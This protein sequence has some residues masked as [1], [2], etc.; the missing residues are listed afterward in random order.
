MKRLPIMNDGEWCMQGKNLKK[1]KDSGRITI[2]CA[3]VA[4]VIVVISVLVYHY[5]T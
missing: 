2:I 1:Y 5:L 3:S 4:L